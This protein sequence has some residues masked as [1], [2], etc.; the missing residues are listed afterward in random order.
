MTQRLKGEVI[1]L[2]KIAPTQEITLAEFLVYAARG[3]LGKWQF[4]LLQ[5][6]ADNVQSHSSF[7]EKEWMRTVHDWWILF[8]RFSE[9]QPSTGRSRRQ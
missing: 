5:P 3:Q 9:C 1:P 7:K 8:D 6:F 4:D 2:R